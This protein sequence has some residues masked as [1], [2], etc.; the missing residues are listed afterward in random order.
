MAYERREAGRLLERGCAGELEG[1]HA[2]RE[3]VDS[4]RDA[5]S[6]GHGRG[7]HV[8]ERVS[9]ADTSNGT[10]PNLF[11]GTASRT[12]ARWAFT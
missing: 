6:P 1:D 5:G 10:G 12:E 4:R 2:Q 9:A 3:D 8:G 11:H 7:R